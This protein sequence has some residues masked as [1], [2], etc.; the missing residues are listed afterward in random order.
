M[1]QGG[2]RGGRRL[3]GCCPPAFSA[4]SGAGSAAPR[5]PF[6]S[7]PWVQKTAHWSNPLYPHREL[8][9]KGLLTLSTSD[10]GEVTTD[11]QASFMT[12]SF[13]EIKLEMCL[14]PPRGLQC[15]SL[16]RCEQLNHFTPGETRPLRT[17]GGVSNESLIQPKHPFQ[18]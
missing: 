8:S 4:G 10:L 18:N 5:G 6:H 14:S 3:C 13:Q 12:L 11:H 2:N 16:Y 15:F 9:F 17:D 7:S 1:T